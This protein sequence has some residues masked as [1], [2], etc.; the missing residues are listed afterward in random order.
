MDSL[1]RNVPDHDVTKYGC[2][3]AA[4]LSFS[5]PISVGFG[6]KVVENQS[7]SP[8]VFTAEI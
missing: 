4:S 5:L 3:L 1:Y 2:F 6:R 7:V 8:S